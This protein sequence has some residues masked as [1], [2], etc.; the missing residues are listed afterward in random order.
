MVHSLDL[1]DSSGPVWTRLDPSGPDGTRLDPSGPVW[2]RLAL[3]CCC[4]ADS[5]GCFILTRDLIQRHFS[6]DRY[7]LLSVFV[8]GSQT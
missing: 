4:P 8:T 5:A 1:L 2:T 7:F 6:Q 3:L